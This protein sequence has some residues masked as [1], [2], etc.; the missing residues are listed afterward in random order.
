MPFNG[1]NEY[2][3]IIEKVSLESYTDLSFMQGI[4]GSLKVPITQSVFLGDSLGDI[5]IQGSRILSRS[6]A[7]E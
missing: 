6:W 2:R 3:K 1:C 7:L 5:P 4:L